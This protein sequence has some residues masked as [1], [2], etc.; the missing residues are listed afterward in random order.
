MGS[1]DART[2]R[3]QAE[4]I[5]PE[6]RFEKFDVH[7]TIVFFGS[8]R[9]KSR[10]NA[11]S[12]LK[13][14]RKSGRGV[15]AAEKAL[16]MSRYHED[17]RTLAKRLTHWSKELDTNGKRFVVCTDG[18]PGIMEVANR[19]ASEARGMN[20]GL[21]ISLPHEQHENPYITHHL[22]A[23]FS[24]QL[25]HR[26]APELQWERFMISSTLMSAMSFTGFMKPVKLFGRLAV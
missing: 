8:A 19:G 1:R 23:R 6:T 22:G 10:R 13:A 18:G 16:E 7:D 4:Y 3:I 26:Y 11:Q 15:K 14:A 9:F 17:A 21:N 25:Q 24:S 20:I 12:A 2:L 5:E